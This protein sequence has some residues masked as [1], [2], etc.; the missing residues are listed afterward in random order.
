MRNRLAGLL[1]VLSIVV[2]FY[3]IF[4]FERE[5]RIKIDSKLSKGLKQVNLIL[6]AG[7]KSVLEKQY[8]VDERFGKYY[9][10]I[11]DRVRLK[12]GKYDVDI[13]LIYPDSYLNKKSDLVINYAFR[14]MNNIELEVKE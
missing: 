10:F 14:G 13:F 5:I 11:E 8:F 7:G 6:S 4:P 2:L 3:L 9:G 1:V 12:R